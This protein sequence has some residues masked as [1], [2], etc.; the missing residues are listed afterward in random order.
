MSKG[1]KAPPPDDNSPT[2]WA[3]FVRQRGYDPTPVVEAHYTA[4]PRALCVA[5]AA[6]FGSDAL[7]VRPLPEAASWLLK[8]ETLCTL[9]EGADHTAFVL[10]HVRQGAWGLLTVDAQGDGS[11]VRVL[12]LAP[13]DELRAALLCVWGTLEQGV[14]VVLNKEGA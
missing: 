4:T 3:D 1:R 8:G 6:C 10:S 7:C 13:G 2:P 9:V 5:L 11:R 12:A 14:A